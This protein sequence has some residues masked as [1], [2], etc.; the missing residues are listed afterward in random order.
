[1]GKGGCADGH[2]FN[3]TRVG[4][5]LAR[6]ECGRCDV[7][8][9]DLDAAEDGAVSAP[10]LFRPKKPTI[11]TVLAEEQRRGRHQADEE[12]SGLRGPR[13]AFGSPHH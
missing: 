6:L 12:Q 13:Y 10:G 5:G 7:V 2:S 8:V 11:F 9:I 1:M 3:A 4:A